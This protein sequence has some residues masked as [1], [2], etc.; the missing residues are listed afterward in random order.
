MV[1]GGTEIRNIMNMNACMNGPA[2]LISVSSITNKIKSYVSSALI[3]KVDNL[4][5]SP[6]YIFHGKSD[7]TI[8]ENVDK[9]NEQIYKPYN[10]RIK[11]NYDTMANH[12]FVT[13]N[14]GGKCEILESTQY[15]NNYPPLQVT[16][17]PL[18]QQEQRG[19][20][21]LWSQWIDATLQLYNPVN[22]LSSNGTFLVSHFQLQQLFQIMVSTKQVICMYHLVV[23]KEKIVQYTL[24]YMDVNKVKQAYQ[25]KLS[26]KLENL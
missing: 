24:H 1:I 12:G 6:V 9:V 18:K 13:D 10:V 15:I 4:S 14:Y 11:T 3:D 25:Y 23:T 16:T 21:D 2:T 17:T 26:D 8:A 19:I 22:Y 5:S 7:R 20:F